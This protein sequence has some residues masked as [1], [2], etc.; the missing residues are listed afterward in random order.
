M[1][2]GKGNKQVGHINQMKLRIRFITLPRTQGE[3]VDI[4]PNKTFSG[5]QDGNGE[6]EDKRDKRKYKN[7]EYDV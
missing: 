5:E 6:D 1:V 3:V 7:L 2:Q 4:T